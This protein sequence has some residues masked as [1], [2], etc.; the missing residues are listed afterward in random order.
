MIINDPE[1]SDEYKKG[2][3]KAVYKLMCFIQ[4]EIE[5]NQQKLNFE[6]NSKKTKFLIESNMEFLDRMA[7]KVERI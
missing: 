4:R 5:L 3:Y 2:Y 7:I 6:V 1:K